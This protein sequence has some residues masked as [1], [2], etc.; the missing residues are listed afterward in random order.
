MKEIWRDIVGYEGLYQISNFGNI[1]SLKRIVLSAKRNDFYFTK[2][3]KLLVKEIN[4]GGYAF[5][6]LYK[7]VNGQ[8]VRKPFT[9]HRLV[10]QAFIPN[11]E[12]KPCVNH[13]NGVKTDNR[14]D[15]L[16]WCTRSE[17]ERHKYSTLGYKGNCYGKFGKEHHSS[18]LVLQIKNNVIIAR[19]YGLHEAERQTGIQFKNISACCRNKRKHAGGYEW[20]FYNE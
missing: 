2:D 4:K 12:N 17:N 18:K 5:I 16:E 7:I 15:N 13:K 1:K 6:S 3:E 19:F 11:P 10:A 20:S 14:V 9:I 8:R